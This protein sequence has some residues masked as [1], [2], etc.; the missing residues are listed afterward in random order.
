MK[1]VAILMDGG[2]TRVIV[3]KAGKTYNPDYI[4]RLAQAAVISQGMN[5]FDAEEV[6]RVLYYDCPP[7]NGKV[8]LPVSGEFKEFKDSGAWL[9]DLAE[10][11]LFA[12]RRGILKF[13]GFVPKTV[14]V[15][16]ATLKDADFKPDFEQKGVDMRIGL[17]IATYGD[18]RTVDR[19]IVF[20][21]DTD[22]I[23]AFKH[24]RKCGLQVVLADLPG[25][26]VIGEL[27][28]HVDFVRSVTLP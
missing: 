6:L 13:R 26:S 25:G 3:R 27:R 20:T 18:A 1:K 2:Y 9:D 4:E 11:N 14:P 19:L 10:R 12:V 28:Q 7:F 5:A 17:D 16:P 23:P 15:A 22:C 24:A 8:K 21:A